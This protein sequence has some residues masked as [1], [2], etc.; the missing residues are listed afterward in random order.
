[1]YKLD[2]IEFPS[3]YLTCYESVLMTL[4]K[5]Q[6]IHEESAFMGTQATF[7]FSPDT[8]SVSAKLHL[9]R[10]KNDIFHL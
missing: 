2:Q 5:A 9:H 7:L 8:F 6:G 10:N 4:L 1:M 3:K